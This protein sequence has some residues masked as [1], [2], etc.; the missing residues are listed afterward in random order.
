MVYCS[1]LL[2]PDGAATA[3][4]GR[5]FFLKIFYIFLDKHLYGKQL[6]TIFVLSIN[7]QPKGGQSR[8]LNQKFAT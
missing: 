2:R 8:K 1:K 3:K 6:T 7:N 5:I 4:R